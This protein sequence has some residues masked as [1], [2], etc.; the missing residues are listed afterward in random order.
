MNDKDIEEL[1]KELDIRYVT[2]A[3]F[4]KEVISV[5]NMIY[6][7]REDFIEAMAK[8][9]AFSKEQQ[10]NTQLLNDIYNFLQENKLQDSETRAGLKL[11]EE[12]VD[13]IKKGTFKVFIASKDP[14]LL[15]IK[16]FLTSLAMFFTMIIISMMI[17]HTADAF[18]TKNGGYVA[19]F[20]LI[21]SSIIN[22]YG[23]KNHE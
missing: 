8:I 7:T 9:E 21:T 1:I 23:G 16:T 17:G 19:L 20:T 2:R 13:N 5:S 4:K 14:F 3:D 12:K 15:I 10:V 22:F 18:M 11:I 6:A